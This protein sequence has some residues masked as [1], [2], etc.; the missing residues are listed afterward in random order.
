LDSGREEEVVMKR[1]LGAVVAIGLLASPVMAQSYGTW[2]DL[3][4]TFKIDAGYFRLT[5]TTKLQWNP[6]GGGS[7]EIE[8]ERDLGL[9]NVAHTFWI[10]G[11]WQVGR[12][13]Q[14]ELAYT[15]LNR[16]AFDFTIQ[17][18]FEWGGEVYNAGLSA[19]TSLSSDI[20]GGYY[21]FAIVKN[22]RFEIGPT[23]GIGY[24]WLEA[25][26]QATGTV[27]GPGGGT[28]QRNLDERASQKSP[29]GAIGGYFAGWATER[30]R[31]EGDFLYIKVDFD[32]DEAS[33]TDWRIGAQYY[34]FKNAGLGVQY[35]FNRYSYQ[36]GILSS[37][38]GGEIT[39]KGFQLYLSFL[40]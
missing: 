31:L 33:V 26:I 30:L 15:R 28:E 6:R 40:F 29:T 25:R 19:D 36:R 8:L 39:Y 16:E 14:I 10:D 18:D 2:N 13:H 34:F 11:T 37:D 32:D 9:D 3:P 4:G 17:R 23:I 24:I 5:P 12:R 20:V 21:R 38:L 35:K 7:G 27:T 22:D 1:V